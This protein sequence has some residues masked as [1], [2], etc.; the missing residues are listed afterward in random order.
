MVGTGFGS[1]EVPMV[2]LT[3]D[4]V[5]RM[6]QT[7]Q[8]DMGA[9]GDKTV[10]RSGFEPFFR[11]AE[12]AGRFDDEIW[13][14]I[15]VEMHGIWGT[16]RSV[17]LDESQADRE[18][19]RRA[20]AVIESGGRP[21]RALYERLGRGL[22]SAGR[23]VVLSPGQ[24]FGQ[25]LMNWT[26][27]QD[28]TRRFDARTLFTPRIVSDTELRL[29]GDWILGRP[30]LRGMN[31]ERRADAE[32]LVEFLR[33]GRTVTLRDV[34][35]FTRESGATLRRNSNTQVLW[36]QIGMGGIHERLLTSD[37]TML[38]LLGTLSETEWQ[39]M[40][41]LG[42]VSMSASAPSRRLLLERLLYRDP[43]GRAG[44]TTRVEP[45]T[46]FGMGLPDV[47]RLSVREGIRERDMVGVNSAEGLSVTEGG[48]ALAAHWRVL[49]ES[50]GRLDVGEPIWFQR[51]PHRMATV[52]LT[53]GDGF[54]RE[55]E[56]LLGRDFGVTPRYRL[57]GLTGAMREEYERALQMR[58]AEWEQRNRARG[59]GVAPP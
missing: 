55:S 19:R 29:E 52:T 20:S 2:V 4:S 32:A 7:V 17:E 36:A 53:F 23:D 49:R 26:T 59:E 43:I 50:Y 33:A 13:V 41:R 45:T 58:R 21:E 44:E 54:T 35:R 28:G 39:E 37:W 8:P 56:F 48:L 12:P 38:R 14:E 18:W 47:I 6:V 11:F 30:L 1:E 31:E 10:Y 46:V 51:V 15:P 24:G 42:S 9:R 57:D 40:E 16:S 22:L 5:L 27:A 3:T 25:S 34:A